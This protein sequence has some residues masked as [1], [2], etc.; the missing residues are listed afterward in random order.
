M[1]GQQNVKFY[2]VCRGNL[3]FFKLTLEG[4]QYT[5]LKLVRRYTVGVL[6]TD[7]S[8]IEVFSYSF[9]SASSSVR[10]S[11]SILGDFQNNECIIRLTVVLKIRYLL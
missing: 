6:D 2:L 10:N 7:K 4:L 1:D 8:V 5:S 11:S 9:I 3:S